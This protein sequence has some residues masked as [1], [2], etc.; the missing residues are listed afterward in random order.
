M[1]ERMKQLFF[2]SGRPVVAEVSPPAVTPGRVLVA[3][4]YSAVSAGTEGSAL[5]ES[6]RSLLSRALEKRSR[7]DRVVKAIR[8]GDLDDVRARFERLAARGDAWIVPG[9]SAAG[10]VQAV[11]EGVAD[12]APGDRVA[13]AGAG[14]AMHADLVSVPRNL[15]ARA[16]DRLSL[17]HA[18]TVALGAIALQAVRRADARVGETA[19]VLGLGLLGQM[20]AR[21]LVA[22][23]CRVIAWDPRPERIALASAHGVVGLAASEVAHVPAAVAAL[24]AGHGADQ[25]ILAAPAGAGTVEMAAQSSRRAGLLV[26]LGDTPVAV[27]RET[28]YA[29]EL[30]I[31]MSTSYGPGRY[32]P[33]YEEE[34]HDYPFAHVR[35]SENRNMA[36]WLDLLAGGRV[37]IDDLILAIRDL[38]QAADS[39]LAL[40]RGALESLGLIFRHENAEKS[41]SPSPQ[42]SS[43]ARTSG[44]VSSSVP[45]VSSG[46]AASPAVSR[47]PLP[48]PIRIA[49]LGT[50]AYTAGSILPALVQLGDKVKLEIL[51][52]SVP[53]RRDPLAKQFG[54]ARATESYEE[55]ATASGIDLVVVATRHDQRAALIAPALQAGRAVFSEKPLAISHAE[56][57]RI[58]AALRPDSMLCVGFNRRFA[59]AVARLQKE[60]TPRNGPLQIAYRVQAG[61]LPETHWI[62]GAQGGGRLIGEAVHMVDLFRALAG[63]PLERA[64]VMAGG[65]AANAS[66]SESDAA[67][68]NFALGFRYADGSLATLL[69]TS[70]GSSEHPKERLEVHWDGRSMELDNFTRLTEA[71]RRAPLWESPAPSKGQPQMWRTIVAAL[72]EGAPAPIP[73]SELLETSRTVV[74]LERLRAGRARD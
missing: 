27:A 66:A 18:S 69:Y 40:R 36:A 61:R 26:L 5:A 37:S 33:R 12:F 64:W 42:A 58:E 25:V 57:D 38:D 32:D 70:R 2:H 43:S 17:A 39:Y 11:G 72:L 52:G 6:G 19:L 13:V 67:A 7:V 31:R 47:A 29:R 62:R 14:Y 54:F 73:V 60:L 21:I 20:T 59:P 71:G 23:G 28:A 44:E 46:I 34:G 55:A 16:P 51:A 35:W 50:G 24:T 10:V 63:A 9:Y 48:T 15:V 30:T 45:G 56:I 1:G 68:D 22:C 4:H 8:R 53:A 49:M 65:A 74:E 3:V 41:L